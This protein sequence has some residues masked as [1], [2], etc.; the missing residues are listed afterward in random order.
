MA[1][2]SENKPPLTNTCQ[3]E[4]T[5]APV[6]LRNRFWVLPV[7]AA[8]AGGLWVARPAPVTAVDQEQ[9]RLDVAASVPQGHAVLTQTIVGGH[10]G[11]SAVDLVAVVYPD[12]PRSAVLTV[13]VRDSTG[14]V[15]AQRDFKALAH[16]AAIHIS[17]Q[18]QPHSAQQ[19]YEVQLSG[20]A[21]NRATVWAYDLDGYSAGQLVFDGHPQPGDLR[22]STTYTYL[23]LSVLGDGA[24][25]LGRLAEI[26]APLT[27]V[28]WLPGALMLGVLDPSRRWLRPAGARLGVALGLSIALLALVWLWAGV[29]GWHWSPVSLGTLY[30]VLAAVGV[31]RLI[32]GLRRR[33]WPRPNWDGV[34][35]AGIVLISIVVRLLAV[36]DLAFPAWVDSSH[37]VLV[38]RLIEAA[39]QIP[40]NYQPFLPIGVFYYHFAFHVLTVNLHWMSGQTLVDTTLF[41]GQVLNGLVPLSA[42][43]LAWGLSGRRRAAL[44]AAFVVGLV[45]LF[46][47]YFA[48]W[49]RYTQ[50]TGILVMGPAAAA[51]WRALR[52]SPRVGA[53]GRWRAI[54]LAA[55]LAAGVF[56]AHYRVLLFFVVFAAV[57][58]LS[59]FQQR[60]AWWVLASAA[61]LALAAS[62]PWVVRLVEQAIAPL[63]AVPRNLGTAESYNAFP[64]DYFSSGLE[65]GWLFL[66]LA[67]GLWGLLRRDRAVWA[68]L[69]WTAGVFAVLNLGPATWLVNNNSWAISLFMPASALIGWGTDRWWHQGRIWAARQAARG[70]SWQ[71]A[72]GTIVLAACAG[73]AAF[74]G[75][76]GARTQISV[77]NP[78]TILATAA[79]RDALGW[80]DT[81]LPPSAVVAVNG[82]NWLGGLW[83]GSDGGAW[84]EPATGR[85]TTLPPN[86]YAYGA[87]AY[88]AATN[89]F[90][91]QL[92]QSD[93]AASP[94]FQA[95]LARAGVTHIYIG[96]RGG[97]LKPEMFAGS[98]HYRLLY[99]NGGAWIFEV[100]GS[101]AGAEARP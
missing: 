75:A 83:A 69:T 34:A 95:L 92:A 70:L 2:H 48:T 46:P 63:L 3:Q 16:N 80:L 38:A 32:S 89:N 61:F 98:P 35:L 93:D 14:R 90:N 18:T 13:Q 49:G 54:A 6:I 79:D 91:A 19:T 31:A 52:N 62:L 22:F 25:A 67:C 8:L 20:S 1:L 26:A 50:L 36:R 65:R 53:A 47:G 7:L 86:D 84:I 42:Y 45:S 11:F 87:R 41:L 9:P 23:W 97:P 78:A 40:A 55:L 58:L 10:D 37:H 88:I 66:A 15:L 4:G 33:P 72:L 43:S 64:A 12:N 21:D 96:E 30:F 57:A 99:S 39:G 59:H 71:A 60:Q 29:V 5:I 76:A 101:T 44:A 24:K 28:L 100:A 82:W 73:L 94:G 85:Q 77:L 17:F 27:L 51:L 68:L 74:A 81:H 56:L